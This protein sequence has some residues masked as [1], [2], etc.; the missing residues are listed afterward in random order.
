[1]IQKENL[2]GTHYVIR[3]TEIG[4]MHLQAKTCEL[5]KGPKTNSPLEAL[6]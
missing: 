1:M 2:Q 5:R 4:M 6:W 3:D